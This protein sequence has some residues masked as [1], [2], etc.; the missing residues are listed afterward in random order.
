MAIKEDGVHACVYM[1]MHINYIV[2]HSTT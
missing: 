1:C 2:T